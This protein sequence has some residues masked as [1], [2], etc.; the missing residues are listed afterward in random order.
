MKSQWVGRGILLGGV[1]GVKPAKVVILGGG[2]EERKLQKLLLEWTA[3]VVI[4]DISLK[5]LR[6]LDDIMPKNVQTV[7]SN[8]YNIVAEIKDA[9]LVV[10]GVLIPEQKHHI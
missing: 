5:R 7:M 8:H 9:D 3:E 1:P 2:I 4:M 10:G 6:E